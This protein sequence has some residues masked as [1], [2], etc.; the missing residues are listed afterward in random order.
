[1]FSFASASCVDCQNGIGGPCRIVP[2]RRL[3]GVFEEAHQA[4]LGV[5]NDY[6]LADL[7]GKPEM[8]KALLKLLNS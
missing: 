6:T 4:F 7:V 5:M 8:Q 1:M 3:K 2:S